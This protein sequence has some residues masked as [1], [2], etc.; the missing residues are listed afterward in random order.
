M[1]GEYTQ[2]VKKEPDHENEFRVMQVVKNLDI[3]ADYFLSATNI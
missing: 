1:P 3:G 2:P